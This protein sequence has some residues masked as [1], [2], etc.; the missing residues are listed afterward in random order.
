MKNTLKIFKHTYTYTHKFK[1]KCSPKI[2]NVVSRNRV[3]YPYNQLIEHL[4]ISEIYLKNNNNKCWM[5]RKNEL[6]KM[7]NMLRICFH[8]YKTHLSSTLLNKLNN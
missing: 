7:K 4:T 2:I 3:E 8:I 6:K 1:K 5:G